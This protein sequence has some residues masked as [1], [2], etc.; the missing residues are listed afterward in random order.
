MPHGNPSCPQK[1]GVEKANCEGTLVVKKSLSSRYLFRKYLDPPKKPTRNT[2]SE[3]IGEVGYLYILYIYINCDI[4]IYYYKLI[5]T[6]VERVWSLDALPGFL[7]VFQK[8]NPLKPPQKRTTN[9]SEVKHC[10]WLFLVPVKG[11]RWHIIPQLAV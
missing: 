11:G 1:L 7:P 3:G 5:F 10:Q 4:Y 8:Q 6:S 2:F 9:I